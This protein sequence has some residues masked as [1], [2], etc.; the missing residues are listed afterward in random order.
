MNA[1][2]QQGPATQES[3]T[4]ELRAVISGCG[5]YRGNQALISLTGRD[6][7]RW[8]NGMVTNNIRDLAADR[9]VYAF[10]LNPQGSILGDLYIFN[11]GESLI[12]QIDR[13]QLETLLA[14]FRKYIIMDKVEIADLSDT[15]SVIGLFGPRSSEILSAAGF[16]ISNPDPLKTH[17]CNFQGSDLTIVRGDSPCLQNYELWIPH[18]A[19]DSTSEALAQAGAIEIAGETRE[20]LRILCGIPKFGQDIREK[21]LPQET[22][23]ERALNFTK[24]CYIGQEIV[25][26]IRSRGSVHRMFTGFTLDR[27]VASGTKIQ[28]DGKD[29]G[30]ITSAATVTTAT[31]LH[32][33]GLGYVRKEFGT[34]GRELVA[35]DVKLRTA[36]IPFS[37][38]LA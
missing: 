30:E 7:V 26:R 14:I 28:S 37:D 8:L 15:F 12:A 16:N 18:D 20:T 25:E 27:A 21:I 35:G 9:G 1:V 29:V 23:Q 33:I 24:G 34:P 4:H 38:L 3:F 2:L 6:R 10:V 19:V 31:G 11:R 36:A 22:G 17:Q 5:F 32:T 13:T